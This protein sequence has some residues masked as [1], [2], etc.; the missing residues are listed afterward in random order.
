MS[1]LIILSL[2]NNFLIETFIMWRLDEKYE[3][4]R[5]LNFPKWC[6]W[7]FFFW[8]GIIEYTIINIYGI[9]SLSLIFH[10]LSHS[11]AICFLSIIINKIYNS[12]I[13]F[14]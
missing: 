5:P 12:K 7:C 10:V 2:F 8:C 14:S 9:L 13:K 11:G 6:E 3:F 1:K 4:Y